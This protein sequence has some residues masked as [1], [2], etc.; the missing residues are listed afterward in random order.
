MSTILPI[1]TQSVWD[2]FVTQNPTSLNS[3]FHQRI[4]RKSTLQ[5]DDTCLDKISSTEIKAPQ[6]MRYCR[7]ERTG[8]RNHSLGIEVQKIPGE[9]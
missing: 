5:G 7:M 3:E 2:S 4:Y 8:K 6:I 1:D 9:T